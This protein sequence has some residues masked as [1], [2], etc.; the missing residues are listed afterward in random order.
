MFSYYLAREKRADVYALRELYKQ[1][2]INAIVTVIWRFGA[3]NF[4]PGSE[5]G[6][7]ELK[8]AK[9]SYPSSLERALYMIG[10]LVAS[11]IDVPKI[12]SKWEVA[13]KCT[14]AEAACAA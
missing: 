14:Q 6:I 9:E 12:L 13:S 4:N 3:S 11:G 1:G 7:A 10:F 8:R 2:K 5:A